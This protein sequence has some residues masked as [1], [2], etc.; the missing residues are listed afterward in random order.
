[1]ATRKVHFY[2]AF[3]GTNQAGR[4]LRYD[5]E[6]ALRRVSGIPFT[7]D[8]RYLEWNDDQ[9]CCWVDSHSPARQL[10]LGKIRREDL[11]ELEQGGNLQPLQIPDNSGIA[12]ITHVSFFPNNV[13]G[14]LFNFYGP[15]VSVLGHYL[16]DKATEETPEEL[17]FE[18]LVRADVSDQLARLSEVRL[19]RLNVRPSFIDTI[20]EADGSLGAAFEAAR[21]AGSADQV[22]IVLRPEKYS[23]DFISRTLLNPIRALARHSSVG[24]EA[25]TFKVK[26]LDEETGGLTEIDVLRDHLMLERDVDMVSPRSRVVEPTSAYEAIHSAFRDLEDEIRSAATLTQ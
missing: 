5:P 22:E 15:R 16:R 3:C 24:E 20:R 18:P 23:R 26:G 14:V 21:R 2:R 17:R 8:V 7:G 9:V 12:E 13:V 4:P 25:H 10:R 11:P 6:P 19:L 1:M